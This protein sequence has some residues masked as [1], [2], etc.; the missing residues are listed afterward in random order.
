MNRIES[1]NSIEEFFR[2]LKDKKCICFG[3]GR[4]LDEICSDIP[5]LADRIAYIMDNN[6]GLHGTDRE[7][8][9]QIKKVYLPERLCME[10]ISTV[11]L[12]LTSTYKK[13]MTEQLEKNAKFK[14]L[15]Y[16]EVE[17]LLDA[18]AWSAKCPAAGYRK[19]KTEVIPR[20]IH[21]IWFSENPVPPELQKNIDGWKRLCPDYEICRWNEKNYDVTKNPYMYKAYKNKKWSFVSDYA[22]LDIIY[23]NG[24]IYLDTDVEMIRRPD[25]LLYNNAFIGFER[26]S[27]V[28]TG[29]GFGAEKGFPLI[30]EMRDYYENIEFIDSENPDDMV[31]CPIYETGILSRHGLKRNGNFQIV[32]GMSVYPVMYFNAKSLYS[33]RLKI[34]EE[35][36]S[37][38]HC[39][40]TWAGSK[41]K[42]KTGEKI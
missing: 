18:M 38:H 34:T 37:V 9:G 16:C 11:F 6:P 26:L 4:K 12:I 36:V 15:N 2:Q 25:E 19:N 27:T 10:D 21:Y 24:G 23:Q 17:P 40:W 1:I 7:I 39:S 42:I 41:S 14:E 5:Q 22:R 30:G 33:D 31:L 8:V 13:E 28:N 35:T 32:S 20:K 29:S 3:A